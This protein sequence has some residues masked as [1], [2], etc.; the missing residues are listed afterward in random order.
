[1]SSNMGTQ[2]PVHPL[3]NEW[4][5]ETLTTTTILAYLNPLS[6]INWLFVFFFIFNMI[7]CNKV[8]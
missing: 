7:T 8:N 1:M 6:M 2:N 3:R 4:I 5:K